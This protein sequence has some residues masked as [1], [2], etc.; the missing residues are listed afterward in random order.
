MENKGGQLGKKGRKQPKA[1]LKRT[2][3]K[4]WE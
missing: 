2:V 4:A 1:P 3:F